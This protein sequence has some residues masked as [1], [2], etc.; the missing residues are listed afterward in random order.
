MEFNKIKILGTVIHSVRKFNF[1]GSVIKKSLILR[2]S[3]YAF[4]MYFLIPISLAFL[5][6]HATIALLNSIA[7]ASPQPSILIAIPR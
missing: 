1:T 7:F 4:K 5:N 3:D 2:S 6:S